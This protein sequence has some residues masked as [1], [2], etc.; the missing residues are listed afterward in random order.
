[1]KVFKGRDDR[2]WRVVRPTIQSILRSLDCGPDFHCP[3]P[4]N[5]TLTPVSYFFGRK[6]EL[7][8]IAAYLHKPDR[9]W[10]ERRRRT[11]RLHNTRRRLGSSQI[12]AQFCHEYGRQF[13][14]ILW[15]NARSPAEFQVSCSR[16]AVALK[17]VLDKEKG[18]PAVDCVKIK[19]WLSLGDE[20]QDPHR[21]RYCWLVVFDDTGAMSSEDNQGTPSLR[22]DVHNLVVQILPD[23]ATFG[24]VLVTSFGGNVAEVNSTSVTSSNLDNSPLPPY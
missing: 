13:A 15:F 17:L 16:N 9:N 10:G 7:A 21:R 18:Q 2:I 11:V 6:D 24:S 22:V 8:C 14:T 5:T 23:S 20:I 4:V 19:E 3:A 1:M 12:A